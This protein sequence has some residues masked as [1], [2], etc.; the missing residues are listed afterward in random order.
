MSTAGHGISK[1]A[2]R[3]CAGLS[4][5]QS[6]TVSPSKKPHAFRAEMTLELPCHRC[7]ARVSSQQLSIAKARL[8]ATEIYLTLNTGVELTKVPVLPP[9]LR[10]K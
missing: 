7:V 4:D 10:L 3:K 2:E 8:Q 6:H 9:S 5:M 1:V